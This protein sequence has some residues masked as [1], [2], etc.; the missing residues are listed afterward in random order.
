MGKK[1]ITIGEEKVG[2]WHSGGR[3]WGTLYCIAERG[4][5]GVNGGEEM[6]EMS[7]EK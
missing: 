6:C 5:S 3:V 7:P 2:K 1:Y 4:R